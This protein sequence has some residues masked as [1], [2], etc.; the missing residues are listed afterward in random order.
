[1]FSLP[2]GKTGHFNLE[3]IAI[4]L[5]FIFSVIDALTNAACRYGDYIAWR[6]IQTMHPLDMN[7]IGNLW[8]YAH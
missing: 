5:S 4:V 1:M 8:N 6:G 2:N 7:K 3:S